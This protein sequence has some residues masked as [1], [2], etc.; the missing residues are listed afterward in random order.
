MTKNI[1]DLFLS[2]APII[3][4]ML[5]NNGFKII[6]FWLDVSKKEQSRRFK[7]RQSNPLK[8]GKMSPIDRVSQDKWKEYT[9]AEQDIFIKTNDSST[10]IFLVQ[11]SLV[12][13]HSEKQ[14][15][16]ITCP[17]CSA[18]ETLEITK[19]YSLH[20]YRCFACG[21]ILKPKSGDCCIFC[22]FSDLDCSSAEQN[23]AS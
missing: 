15:S 21:G 20:L 11:H 17:H 16:T 23:L 14:Y 13:A 22:S 7:E 5:K 10:E 19:G 12:L 9:E 4:Q 18:T 1:V 6:K 3:E 2:E 8:L